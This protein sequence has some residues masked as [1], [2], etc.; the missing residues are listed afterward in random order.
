MGFFK[1][2]FR[3]K[4]IMMGYGLGFGLSFRGKDKNASKE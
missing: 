3:E 4:Q 2:E 1:G